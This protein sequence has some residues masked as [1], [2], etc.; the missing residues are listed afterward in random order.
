MDMVTRLTLA[1]RAAIHGAGDEPSV[2]VV[3]V[4]PAVRVVIRRQIRAEVGVLSHPVT[5]LISP[6][7]NGAV[8]ESVRTRGP[9]GVMCL[10]KGFWREHL[11]VLWIIGEDDG[12]G[13]ALGVR[14]DKV[15]CGDGREELG[16]RR[17][18]QAI[19]RKPL[20]CRRL[21]SKL[22]VLALNEAAW[23]KA[24]SERLG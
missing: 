8:C 12:S 11:H 20:V 23:C 14:M 7:G 1:I 10:Y 4:V 3:R 2:V 15:S 5:I 22:N 18:W 9:G 19:R 13:V 24:I 17:H 21:A 16:S 6:P